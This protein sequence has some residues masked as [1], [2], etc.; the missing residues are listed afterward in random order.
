VV[1][2]GVGAGVVVGQ[3]PCMTSSATGPSALA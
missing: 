1:G 2:F 3:V